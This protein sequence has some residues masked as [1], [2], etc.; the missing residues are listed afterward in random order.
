MPPACDHLAGISPG[1][2]PRTAG[3]EGCA[4]LGERAWNQLRVCL[5]C[6]HVGCC[7]DSRHAHALAHFQATGHPLIASLEAGDTW[8]WCYVH[9]RYID[10][11]P[12]PLPRPKGRVQALF[13]RLR[14]R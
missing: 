8:G 14:G 7:E 13:A 5:T 3:C 2:Q 11:M 10:P 1:V 9:H 6:G 12:F 4:A